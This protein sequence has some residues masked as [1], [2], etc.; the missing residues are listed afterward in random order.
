MATNGTSAPGDGITGAYTGHSLGLKIAMATFTGIACYN[1]IE[2]VVLVFVTFRRYR[3]LYFWSLLLSAALGVLPYSLG[4]LLKLF[5]LTSAGWLSVTLLTLGWYPM[6]TG[7]SVVLYSRLHL[8]L[9]CPQAL[10][11]VLAMIVVDAVCLHLPTTVLTYGSNFASTAADGAFVRGYHVMEKIQMT[12]F[13]LQELVLS[14]LYIVETVRM[15]RL[16]P[17]SA[18]HHHRR[19]IM[20]QLLSIN[21]LIILLDLGL[22]VVEYLDFYLIETTLKGAVYSVKLKLE[23]AVLGK[24]VHLVHDRG[25]S[26]SS[27]PPF[28]DFVDASR[29]PSD[30]TH[31]VPSSS[32]RQLSHPWMHADDVSIAIFEHSEPTPTPTPPRGGGTSEVSG[33]TSWSGETRTNQSCFRSPSDWTGSACSP[34]IITTRSKSTDG[35]GSSG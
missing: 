28:P 27:S 16:N 19:R 6:V 26:P 31:A 22:L 5:D 29:V 35:L 8:V 32:V 34:S 12:G 20:Y 24:L 17:D 14:G 23:F 10:R 1:A 2:L 3:G 30:L 9:R 21:L 11:R 4:F 13:C 15:L 33:S 7:Q 18:H 25:H